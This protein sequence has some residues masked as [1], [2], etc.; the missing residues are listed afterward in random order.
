MFWNAL[1]LRVL[2]N[3]DKHSTVHCS[4]GRRF[5]FKTKTL[6]NV[7]KCLT[8]EV[9]GPDGQSAEVLFTYGGVRREVLVTEEQSAEE[10]KKAEVRWDSFKSTD[11]NTW[12]GE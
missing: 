1:A 11:P 7:I 6:Q 10:E 8:I 12:V 5:S 2:S 4:L 3:C 9:Q